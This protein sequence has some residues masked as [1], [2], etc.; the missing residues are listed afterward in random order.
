MLF[1]SNRICEAVRHEVIRLKRTH[2]GNLNLNGLPLG[3]YRFLSP[4][5]IKALEL[6]AQ[7]EPVEKK[8]ARRRP[9]VKSKRTK[10]KR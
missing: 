10:A 8:I 9:M 3:A 6:M 4:R 7:K 2:F 1:R 5:E